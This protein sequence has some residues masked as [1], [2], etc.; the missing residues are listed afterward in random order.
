MKQLASII[1]II[2]VALSGCASNQSQE[3]ADTY[4]LTSYTSEKRKKSISG[5]K[6]LAPYGF[7][8]DARVTHELCNFGQDQS[9]NS[10]S[11]PALAIGF[12]ADDLAPAWVAYSLT[13][14]KIKAIEGNR[15]L[16]EEQRLSRRGFII[17]REQ[18]SVLSSNQYAR[19]DD[20]TNNGWD[21]GHLAPSGSMTWSELAWTASYYTTN[22]APQ[23]SV[24]N[25]RPWRCL[26]QAIRQW[27]KT[28]GDT[29]VIVGTLDFD[30]EDIAIEGKGGRRIAVPS[31]FYSVVYQPARSKGVAIVTSNAQECRSDDD[32]CLRTARK[33]YFSMKGYLKSIDYLEK[34][35]GLDF[36][37]GLPNNKEQ[38]I[39]SADPK[40]AD[41][42]LLYPLPGTVPAVCKAI[43]IS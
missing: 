33:R 36:L 21:R 11:A 5:C 40:A 4:Q 14:N 7:P 37:N 34:L 6:A 32:S 17:D 19:S 9:G 29:H 13:K 41:W 15:A 39:E 26:E 3:A 42:P 10:G 28:H 2:L 12:S 35:S 30:A 1:G 38:K 22:I 24:T 31:T 16:P 23:D 18:R 8:I 20:Y 43:S 27:A 25:R